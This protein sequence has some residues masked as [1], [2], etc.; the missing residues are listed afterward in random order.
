MITASMNK[1]Y[2]NIKRKMKT[3]LFVEIIFDLNFC[4][5]FLEQLDCEKVILHNDYLIILT[6]YDLQAR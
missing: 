2:L 4:F 5:V 1:S 6:K 3:F